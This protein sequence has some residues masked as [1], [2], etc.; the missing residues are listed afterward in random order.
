MIYSFFSLSNQYLM[1]MDKAA[2]VQIR[3]FERSFLNAWPFIQITE[4]D[5]NIIF[6]HIFYNG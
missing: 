4:N 2:K 3:R 1:E 6:S 5:F